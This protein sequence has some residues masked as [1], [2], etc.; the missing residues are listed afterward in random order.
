MVKHYLKV[1][2]YEVQKIFDYLRCHYVVGAERDF[3]DNGL[4][5]SRKV[6]EF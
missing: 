3:H 1:I 4:A 2:H 6:S 5:V